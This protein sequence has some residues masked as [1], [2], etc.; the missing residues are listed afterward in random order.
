MCV[1][2]EVYYITYIYIGDCYTCIP[3]Q[4]ATRG[5]IIIYKRKAKKNTCVVLYYYHGNRPK[6]VTFANNI[7]KNKKKT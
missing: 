4:L 2:G 1:R 7:I 6:R 3:T 5:Y